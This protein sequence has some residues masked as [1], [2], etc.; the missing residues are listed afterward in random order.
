MKVKELI[1]ALRGVNQ[2]AEV[3]YEISTNHIDLLIGEDPDTGE[4]IYLEKPKWC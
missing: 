3:G 4:S 2:E 1:E